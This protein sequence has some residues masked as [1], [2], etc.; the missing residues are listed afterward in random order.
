MSNIMPTSL[1]QS[2]C[3]SPLFPYYIMCIHTHTHI[4][5]H[6]ICIYIFFVMFYI[7]SKMLLLQ[8]YTK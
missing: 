6:S 2:S 4:Y 7:I 1:E 5:I 8:P 3:K